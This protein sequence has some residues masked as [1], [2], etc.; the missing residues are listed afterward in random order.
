MHSA[1]RPTQSRSVCTGRARRC[2]LYWIPIF[3]AKAV[4]CNLPETS[5]SALYVEVPLKPNT[6]YRLSGWAKAADLIG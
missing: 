3:G 2:V 1:S 6:E 4:T 5:F